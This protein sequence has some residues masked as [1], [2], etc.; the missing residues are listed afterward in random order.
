MMDTFQVHIFSADCPFYDG[1]C[2]SLIVPTIQGQYGIW[3]NHSN[4]IAA[5]LPGTLSYRIPGEEE[6]VAAVSEGI[7]KIENNDVM[8]LVDTIER[9]EEIDENR[10]RIEADK[11]K[12][13]LL[14]KKSIR[15]YHA[16]QATMA[17]AASRLR[18]KHNYYKE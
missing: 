2:E 18:V 1:P 8:V 5:V 7:I 10:A 15:E 13:I 3:A 14:Q 11:A 12:E 17:R 9:P 4:M 6:K 16:A